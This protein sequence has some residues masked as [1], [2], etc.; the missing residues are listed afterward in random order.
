M[1]IARIIERIETAVERLRRRGGDPVIQPF[2][3][4][5][6]PTAL[7]AR[8]RVLGRPVDGHRVIAAFRTRELAGV[9]VAGGGAGTV[10][11]EEGYFTLT[12]PRWPGAGWVAV[13]VTAGN[14][15]ATLPVLVPR[16]D[17]RLGVISDID[18]TL[19]HTGAWSL[20]R[21]LWT[22]LRG[23][24]ETRHVFPD[25]V[26]LIDRLREGGR[27]PVFYVSSGPWNLLPFLEEVF[28]RNRLPRGPMFMRDWGVTRTHLLAAP[29]ADHKAQAIDTI[30]SANPGLSFVL[31][32][33]TG[34][35]DAAIYLAAAQR[36][37]GRIARVILRRAGSRPP[38]IDGFA[39]L[40]VRADVVADFRDIAAA[41]DD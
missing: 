41:Q 30:L 34:Q 35:Q 9:P 2:P 6:T 23:R 5:A 15:H 39:G 36:H 4:H 16:A 20:P 22:T 32:G 18:D 40:G 11:D 1:G 17:A 38:A 27:N 26:T 13:P 25:A 28:R 3:G 7:V 19:M 31:I 12:L 33:D 21:N 8:G 24:P 14:H 37:P 29:H 10:T